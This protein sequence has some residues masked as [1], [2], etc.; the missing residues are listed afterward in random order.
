[1]KL[2]PRFLA[3]AGLLLL[4][5]SASAVVDH[6]YLQ[7][8]ENGDTVPN[9]MP[10]T[11]YARVLK[12]GCTGLC[13]STECAD[14]TATLF[15]RAA[16]DVDYASAPMT[17]NVGDCYTPEDEYVG[18][19]PVE[20]LTAASVEFY[21]EF[22][23]GDG[24]APF[25]SRPGS[26]AFTFTPEE[27]A[28]YLVVPA[29]SAELTLHVVGDFH[30]VT[31]DGQGPGISGSFNGWAFQPM[32]ALGDHQYG[33]DIVWPAGSAQS[34]EFKFRNGTGWETL[35]GGPFDNREYVV[36][37]GATEDDYFGYW[38]DEEECQCPELPTT[39]TVSVIF[40]VDMNNQDPASYAGGVSVQGNRAPLTWNGG[41]RLLTD[42][43]GDGVYTNLVQF[44]IGT[45]TTLEFKFT[46]SADGVAWDW[47]QIAANRRI[48]L[49]TAGGFLPADPVFFSDY[50]PAT[51]TTVPVEVT[52]QL[53]LGCFDPA[54]YAGG[55][56]VQGGAAPLTWDGG[57]TPMS[58]VDSFF[59][60]TVVFPAGTPVLVEYK[61]T[62][63]D[64]VVW[65]WED[66]IAN[67]ELAL[68]D[69]APTVVLGPVAF[70]DW[71]C[72]PAVTIS[73]SA[74]NVVLDWDD[75]PTA[76]HYDVYGADD[77]Y[78][79]MTLLGSVT[80]STA[81]YPATGRKVYR[82]VAVK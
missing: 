5:Q 56:S 70:D 53:D 77:A 79:P 21:C 16:G 59:D 44:P 25:T 27:P 60:V 68:S 63:N 4:A 74:S 36:A 6:S 71:F 23:D 33:Y 3:L 52:F 72:S 66:G 29:T 80:A 62:R 47:E 30:C 17:L 7:W 39:G 12:T 54:D 82:V 81:T 58:G 15:Y 75:V 78:V 42:V 10:V 37:D 20:A 26:E 1:M 64:G 32:A 65:Q 46:K 14:L 45:L 13:D 41:D 22:A 11:M 67:R 48:C 49:P 9:S 57:S 43:D 55:V 61:F 69:D 24:A 2:F 18:V 38:N 34:I 40:A 8:Q 50:V 19:I 28:F 51:E 76:D 31:P 73:R 35:V